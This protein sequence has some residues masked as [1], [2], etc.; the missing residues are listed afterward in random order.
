M[1]LR[2]R[3]IKIETALTPKQAVLLWLKEVQQLDP[4]EFAERFF[5]CPMHEAPR[6]RIP[7]MAEKAVRD[8]LRKKGLKP[9]SVSEAAHEAWKRADFM[10]VLVYLLND[11]IVQDA[12]VSTPCLRLL[13]VELGWMEEKHK[14]HGL[15]TAWGGWRALFINTMTRTL[16]LRATIEAISERMY[17]NHSILF[18]GVETSLNH[19]IKWAELLA[20]SYN[21]LE[22]VLPSWTAIDLAALRS[23]IEAEVPA[24]VAKQ[25][26]HAKAKTLQALGEWKAAWDLLEPY[27]LAGIEKLRCSDSREESA[28]TTT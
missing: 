4:N 1:S 9:E 6:V 13:L 2:K 22:G 8:S 17:D 11:E 10:L 3:L 25:V 7:E 19:R 24:E 5:K 26:A 14:E 23:S 16:L 21:A 27:A 15:F 28:G 20:A 12:R 18:P